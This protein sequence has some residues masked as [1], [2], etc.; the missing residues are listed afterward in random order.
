[1]VVMQNK[2][3]QLAN[4]LFA[5]SHFIANAA[6]FGY[7][8]VNPTFDEY[9][10]LFPA[11]ARDDFGG[12]DISVHLRPRMSFRAFESCSR[13]V[14]KR[15]PRSPWHHWYRLEGD[16]VAF[17]L[18]DPGYLGNA[19]SKLVF[20]TGWQFR[21]ATSLFKHRPLIQACFRPGPEVVAEVDA[22]RR[23]AR[24]D[25]DVLV[26]VHIRR[27]DYARWEQGRYFYELADYARFMR[28]A[29]AGFKQEGRSVAFLVCSNEALNAAMF[30]GLRVHL[31]PGHPL[32][33]LY[34]L[35][36]CDAIMG[37]PST[38]SLWA[39][40]YGEARLCHI[41]GVQA[42]LTAADFTV[43]AA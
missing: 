16:H 2:A 21:D 37:P 25:A 6:E 36:S 29:Q 7:R 27:G 35:A 40:Y 10:D 42:A 4:R 32:K 19:R 9:R 23:E 34:A 11:V 38:Y 18:R 13:S 20:T 33:D 39:A 31:A 5:F 43:F 12:H 24:R 26:G 8:L 22:C 14:L 1:M 30:E 17:D 15:L 28:A 3:G 41:P